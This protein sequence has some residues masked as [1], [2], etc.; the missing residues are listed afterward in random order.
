MM[1]GV[2]RKLGHRGGDWSKESNANFLQRLE[3]NDDGVIDV[4]EFTSH[5]S[6]ALPKGRTDFDAA[7]NKFVEVANEVARIPTCQSSLS[8]CHVRCAHLSV[9]VTDCTR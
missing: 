3:Q 7:I 8:C 2:R 1:T 5:F 6:S 9:C 4:D